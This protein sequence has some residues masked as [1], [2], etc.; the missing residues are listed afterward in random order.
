MADTGDLL[1]TERELEERKKTNA[2]YKR[3]DTLVG[4]C[5]RLLT[6]QKWYK[7]KQ[8][9]VNLNSEDRALIDSQLRV[10]QILHEPSPLKR[11]GKM[12]NVGFLAYS[13]LDA[14]LFEG[15]LASQ[16]LKRKRNGDLLDGKTVC[17]HEHM[18]KFKDALLHGAKIAKE[19]LT[20]QFKLQCKAYLQSY[21]KEHARK[22]S[23]GLTD[24]R[25]ENPMP[26]GLK[27]FTAREQVK[28]G[29][30][31]QVCFGSQSWNNISRS[32]NTAELAFHQVG[33]NMDA[34][35]VLFDQTKADQTGAHCKAKHQYANTFD[36][37]ICPLVHWALYFALCARSLGQTELVFPDKATATRR[38]EASMKRIFKDFASTVTCLMDIK[39]WGTHSSR[40][41][42]TTHACACASCVR[43]VATY[44]HRGACALDL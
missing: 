1:L 18:R 34:I 17:S 37:I 2:S 31:E 13:V 42:A 20:P 36:P 16:K 6:I 10:E 30:F 24:E 44:A 25:A 22:K 39:K 12:Y 4:H 5:N 29:E 27:D 19:E 40:K 14:S 43:C 38:Y 23:E 3:E 8:A 28:R 15:F 7:G 26:R 21:E 41:G 32:V 11:P 33:V 35:G 9:L